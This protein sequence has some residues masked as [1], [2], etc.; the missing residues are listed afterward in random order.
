MLLSSFF[1]LTI[2]VYKL[3]F[4]NLCYRKHQPI[5]LHWFLYMTSLT[6]SLVVMSMLA[7]YYFSTCHVFLIENT[8][9]CCFCGLF[10]WNLIKSRCI[11]EMCYFTLL[12]C[13]S[14]AMRVFIR[15]EILE[16]GYNFSFDTR[17][18]CVGQVELGLPYLETF[19]Q[20]HVTVSVIIC[21]ELAIFS[22][23][24]NL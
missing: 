8:F 24:L 16:H 19:S 21:N 13:M 7:Q 2:N 6:R 17:Y 15:N 1:M 3:L 4:C 18:S 22:L 11:K 20:W 23:F 9:L 10:A 14:N 12:P 5:F